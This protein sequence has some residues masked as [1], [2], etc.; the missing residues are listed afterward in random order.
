MRVWFAAAAGAS[1]TSPIRTQ[2]LRHVK[3]QADVN[4]Q[5]HQ[6]LV[7]DPDPRAQRL[8]VKGKSSCATPF[9]RSSLITYADGMI[10]LL[11]TV[12]YHP[13]P[14]HTHTH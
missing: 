4:P 11:H 12:C 13:P 1:L 3:N 5:Q 6:V 9:D 8:R 10:A 2:R 7:G 14:F